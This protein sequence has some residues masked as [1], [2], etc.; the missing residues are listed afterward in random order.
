M[1]DATQRCIYF[2]E[3]AERNGEL[4]FEV[5]DNVQ[6]VM[7]FRLTLVNGVLGG[8]ATVGGQVSKVAVVQIGG[9]S[10]DRLPSGVTAGSATGAG[11]GVGSGA[12]VGGGVFRVGGGISAPVLIRKTEPQYTVEARVAK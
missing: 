4:A 8:E 2:V 12:A 3:V 7:Q 9:G 10:G 11:I 6:R 1:R 5:N